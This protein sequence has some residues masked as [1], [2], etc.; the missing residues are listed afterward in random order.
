MAEHDCDE[1]RASLEPADVR[2]CTLQAGRKVFG[3]A[4]VAL[5]LTR[6]RCR[7]GADCGAE[8]EHRC[9]QTEC[10]RDRAVALQRVVKASP[11]SVGVEEKTGGESDGSDAD[12]RERN[13]GG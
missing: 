9:Q 13:L 7:E 8:R 3:S 6:P 5:D 12:G 2:A 10:Y 11:R 4:E 1:V